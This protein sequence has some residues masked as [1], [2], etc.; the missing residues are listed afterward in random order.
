MLIPFDV[1]NYILHA[2]ANASLKPLKG[3]FGAGKGLNTS[4]VPLSQWLLRNSWGVLDICISFLSVES[5]C[6]YWIQFTLEFGG[7][8]GGS[9]LGT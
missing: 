1:S 8:Y 5:H 7:H 9:F 6:L 3:G 4:T 2:A